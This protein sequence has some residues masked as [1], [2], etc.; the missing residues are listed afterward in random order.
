MRLILLAAALA[1]TGAISVPASAIEESPILPGYWESTSKV[2]FPLPSSKTERKCLSSEEV[3][4]FLTGPANSH[5]VCKYD[6][7]HFVGGVAAMEG[8]CIDAGVR[9][10]VKVSGNYTPTSFQ[11]TSHLNAL[12]GGLSIPIDAS[13]DAHR[14]SG[15]CPIETKADNG[16]RKRRD[17]RREASRED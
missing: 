4:K 2:S 6:K 5:Y 1:V 15:E 17:D 3:V 13:I 9:A 7:S 12:F 16:D 11:L 14:L 10:K 8:E